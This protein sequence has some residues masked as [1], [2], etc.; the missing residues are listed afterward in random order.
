M[1]GHDDILPQQGDILE[2]TASRKRQGNYGIVEGHPNVACC[3][4]P[5]LVHGVTPLIGLP[6]E[7][8]RHLDRNLVP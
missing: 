2:R 3:E 1:P 7:R 4:M 8:M 6:W 5:A